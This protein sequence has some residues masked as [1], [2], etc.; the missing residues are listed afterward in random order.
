[1]C[2]EDLLTSVEDLHGPPCHHGE[3]RYAELEIERLA[4]A[5]ECTAHQGLQNAHSSWIDLEDPGKLP[6]EVVR[7]LRGGPDRE[8]P[9]WVRIPVPVHRPSVGLP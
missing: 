7:D 5:A 6:V 3:L 8:L 9:T 2:V 1:M 4:L